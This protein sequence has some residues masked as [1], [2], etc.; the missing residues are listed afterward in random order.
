MGAG[1]RA[2]S[3]CI[4]T[5]ELTVYDEVGQF[6]VL[7]ERSFTHV[8]QSSGLEQS[9]ISESCVIYDSRRFSFNF[10]GLVLFM[11]EFGGGR[12]MRRCLT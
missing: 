7:Q 11:W 2:F 12:N 9:L 8:T 5:R 3:C 10:H 4:T 1:E 6:L